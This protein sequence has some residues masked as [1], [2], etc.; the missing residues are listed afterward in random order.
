MF[1][2]YKSVNNKTLLLTQLTRLRAFAEAVLQKPF[3]HAGRKL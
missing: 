1:T 3:F 2:D